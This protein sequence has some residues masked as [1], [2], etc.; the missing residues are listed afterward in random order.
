MNLS[1][2]HTYSGIRF[3]ILVASLLLIAGC[4]RDEPGTIPPPG[5]VVKGLEIVSTLSI[6]V[7][8][9]S[10][11][12][13]NHI[14]STLYTVSDGNAAYYKFNFNGMILATIPISGSDLEGIV[15]SQNC[16]TIYVVQEAKQL[17]TAFRPDGTLLNSFPVKVATSISSSL[18]GITIDNHGYLVVINE[19][20]PMMVLKFNKTSEIFRKTLSYSLDISDICYDKLTNCFWIVSDESR[21]VLKLSETFE[22]IATY[23][24]NV[25]K[26]EGI[27]VLGDKIYIVSDSESKM[28]VFK[29]PSN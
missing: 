17:V 6:S 18:E 13:F 9:P 5:P 10:A 11:L 26:A 7:S 16:D 25:P 19:K 24:I 28:Y 14:D 4:N 3:I 21:T 22:L 12:A 20:D 1:S 29:K 23:T 15:L 2:E 8:E 27:L